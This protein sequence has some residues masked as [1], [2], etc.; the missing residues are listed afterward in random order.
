MS[1]KN[2]KKST[3]SELGKYKNLSENFLQFKFS[4]KD[5][6]GLICIYISLHKFVFQRAQNDLGTQKTT[7]EVFCLN[8]RVGCP[9]NYETKDTLNS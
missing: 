2:Q 7:F 4:A 8:V 1:L 9:E 3:G 5:P 6:N